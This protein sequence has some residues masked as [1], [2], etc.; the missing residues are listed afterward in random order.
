MKYGNDW[1]QFLA[2]S[3]KESVKFG[4]SAWKEQLSNFG[5]RVSMTQNG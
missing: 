4:L 1:L 2:A 5:F 3:W